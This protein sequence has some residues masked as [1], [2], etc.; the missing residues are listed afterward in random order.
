MQNKT[1]IVPRETSAEIIPTVEI[2][3]EAC[4]LLGWALA[5]FIKKEEHKKERQ[6]IA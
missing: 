5:A 6:E 1:I 2:P 4:K 3:D